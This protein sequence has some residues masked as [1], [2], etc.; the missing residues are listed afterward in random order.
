MK[1]ALVFVVLA[2][3]ISMASARDLQQAMCNGAA[4]YSVSVDFE[5]SGMRHPYMYPSNAQWSPVTLTSHCSGYTMWTPGAT[6]SPGVQMVAEMGD[7]TKLREELT[8]CPDGCCSEPWVFSCSE[9]AGTCTATS[10][11]WVCDER[12]YVSWV[13]MVLPS[14]DWFAGDYNQN[15]CMGGSWQASGMERLAPWDSGT[16]DGTVYTAPDAVTT[17]QGNIFA[18]TFENPTNTFYNRDTGMYMDVGSWSWTLQE[19]LEDGGCGTIDSA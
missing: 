3:G 14:P 1:F 18:R 11:I 15:F 17:P 16:D 7:N 8:N 9:T 19:V 5:W 10:D 12:P 2:L 6:A 13:S 4:R